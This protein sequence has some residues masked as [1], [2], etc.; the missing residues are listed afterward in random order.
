[1]LLK[2]GIFMLT[3]PPK[4]QEK[5]ERDNRSHTVKHIV[6]RTLAQPKLPASTVHP[7]PTTATRDQNPAQEGTGIGR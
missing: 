7:S 6:N 5:K 3:A 1:M 4:A 2:Y